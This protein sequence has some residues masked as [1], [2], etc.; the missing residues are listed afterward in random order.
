MA[1]MKSF[2]VF[3]IKLEVDLFFN[4]IDFLDSFL[5]LNIN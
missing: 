5:I 4:F 1:L 2:S 3:K